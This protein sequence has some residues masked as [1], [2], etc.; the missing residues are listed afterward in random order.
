MSDG[1]E[2]MIAR[3]RTFLAEL[4]QNNDR[5]WLDAHKPVF[6]TEIEAPAKLLTELFEEDLSRLTGVGHE[7]KMGR[8]YRDLRFSKDKSLYNTYLHCYWRGGGH[9]AQGWL[10]NIRPE[11]V[12]LMTGLHALDA[13][14][15]RQYRTALDR[16]GDAL[17]AVMQTAQAAGAEPMSFGDDVLKRVPKPYDFDRPHADLLKRKQIILG[18]RLTE[19][20]MADGLIPAMTATAHDLVPFWKWCRDAMRPGV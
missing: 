1:L 7:G 11:A 6:K 9:P 5:A 14:G 10:L 19:A 18:R 2:A 20:D 17:V 16:D 13:D 12:D 15:V 4:E 3:S 8:I